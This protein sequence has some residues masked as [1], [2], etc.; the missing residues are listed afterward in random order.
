WRLG[1][2]STAT[3]GTSVTKF[4]IKEI[5]KRFKRVIIMFDA[6]ASKKAWELYYT[7]QAI[8]VSGMIVELGKGD[9]A[10]LKQE[11]ANQ[12]MKQFAQLR[13]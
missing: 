6:D 4:Q 10:D 9:P 7:L 11:E 1:D 12:M 13:F 5:R 8:G 3:F 2:N